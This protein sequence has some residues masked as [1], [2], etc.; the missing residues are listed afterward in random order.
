MCHSEVE[1]LILRHFISLTFS[2]SFDVCNSFPLGFV[3][4]PPSELCCK[5]FIIYF[6]IVAT[7]LIG[8]IP[9]RH[10]LQTRLRVKFLLI[11]PLSF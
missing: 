1:E 2:F 9:L 5:C 7:F 3:F 8:K 4:I 11:W 10:R 6:P